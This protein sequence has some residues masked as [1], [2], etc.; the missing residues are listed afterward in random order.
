M[1]GAIGVNVKMIR[2]Y[3]RMRTIRDA[4]IKKSQPFQLMVVL[5]DRIVV[6]LSLRL[7]IECGRGI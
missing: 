2:L 5:L 1:S 4:S 6:K 7:R 3:G